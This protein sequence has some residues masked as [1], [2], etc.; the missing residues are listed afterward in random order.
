MTPAGF[1]TRPLLTRLRKSLAD[2]L[3]PKLAGARVLDLF[4]GSGAIAFE[5]LSNGA[6]SAVVVEI[7]P[8]TADI[9]SQN[10]RDLGV[11]ADVEIFRSDFA[12]ALSMITRRDEEFDII[13]V[14][15][16][17]GFCLQQKAV[18]LL[19]TLKILKTG[20]VVVAQRENNEPVV[21][22]SGQLILVRTKSYGRTVFEFFEGIK[23]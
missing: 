10:S 7:N 14:A 3:R 17:Y 18:S 22:S 13:V 8:G 19:G 1:E 4:G 16:P 23:T 12:A 6:V 11:E 20:G 2:I 9:I 21:N 5:L 15:P